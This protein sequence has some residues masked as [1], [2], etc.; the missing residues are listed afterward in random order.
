MP[1]RRWFGLIFFLIPRVDYP[2]GTSD[3]TAPSSATLGAGPRGAR[4][5]LW[6]RHVPNV[7]ACCPAAPAELSLG[8]VRP[9]LR[10]PA[11][12]SG[13]PHRPSGPGP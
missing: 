1:K 11:S 7:T 4:E 5:T 9:P 2:P 13:L 3:P 6:R 10:F 8:C 12:D